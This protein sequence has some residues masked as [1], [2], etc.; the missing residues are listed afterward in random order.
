[1]TMSTTVDGG[2]IL[3]HYLPS[4]EPSDTP[5]TLFAKT[6]AGA[7]EIYLDFLRN[8]ESTGTF[9]GCPA[10][11]AALL[12]SRRRLDGVPQHSRRA[13]PRGRNGGAARAAGRDHRLLGV[14]EPGSRLRSDPGDDHRPAG[15]VSSAKRVVKRML[16]GAALLPGLAEV[17][18]RSLRRRTNIVY[19][20]YVGPPTPYYADFYAGCTLERFASDLDLLERHFEIVP[21]ARVSRTTEARGGRCSRSRSTTGST[22][23]GAA[24]RRSSRGGD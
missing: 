23:S 13:P 11:A 12:L 9:S 18:R 5:A 14:R 15:P 17:T 8:L 3:G 7:A 19:Y 22:S 20:H 21:L 16:G 24:S 10:A 1:M 2:D 6:V 4:I